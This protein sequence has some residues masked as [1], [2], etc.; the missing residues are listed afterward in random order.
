MTPQSRILLVEDDPDQAELYDQVLTLAGYDVCRVANADMAAARATEQH[1]ALAVVD[2]DL[3]G[4]RGDALIRRFKTRHPAMKTLLYS[5]HADVRQA[6]Q[7]CGADAWIRK[8]D[9]IR[10]LREVVAEQLAAA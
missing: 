4:T 2:W 5:N 10:R 1:F 7:T 6:A 8:S 9:G 3:P